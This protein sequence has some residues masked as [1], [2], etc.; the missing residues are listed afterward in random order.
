EG[1]KAVVEK[2][3][4]LINEHG[5]EVTTVDSWGK[6]RMA[7]EIKDFHEGYYYLVAFQ[8]VPATAQELDRVLKITD[9]ILRFMILRKDN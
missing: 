9:E 8:G 6:R 4:A 5:G 3:S 2:F 1:V 7:Y